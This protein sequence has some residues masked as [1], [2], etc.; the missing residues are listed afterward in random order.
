[1][2]KSKLYGFDLPNGTWFVKMKIDNDELWQEIKSGSLRGLSIEGYFTD[3]F[4]A[5]QKK[6]PTTEQVLKALNEIIR[7]NKTK[8]KAEKIELGI[9]DDLKKDV[10]KARKEVEGAERVHKAA[11]KDNDEVNKLAGQYID[12]K[13]KADK[14]RKDMKGL[15]DFSKEKIKESKSLLSKSKTTA[16]KIEKQLKELGLDEKVI[17]SELSEID[18]LNSTL[19][20]LDFAFLDDLPF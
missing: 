7:E 6:Q 14:K 16:S 5:M 4:E 20:S 18:K 17:S 12:L 11:E 1:M 3:K 15:I 2:D 13:A 8:L 10:E 9:I 19:K